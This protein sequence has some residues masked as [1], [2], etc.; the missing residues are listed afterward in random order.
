MS[1][2]HV[3]HLLQPG[4]QAPNFV[5]DAISREGKIA[6][7]D[8][9]GRSPLLIGLFRGLHCPFCRLHVAAMAQLS[10]ALRE[11]GIESLV[12]VSTPV[13]RARLYFR[14]Q[15]IPNLFA[16]SDPERDLHRAFGLPVL[17]FTHNETD[18]P[19]KVGMDVVM[20]MRVD[21]PGELPEPM[22]PPTA[23]DLLNKKDRYEF[24]EADRQV[25]LAGHMQ[26][27]GHF[28][29]DRESVVR[30]S[31]TEVEDEG[32]NVCQALNPEE[33]LSAASQIA[34]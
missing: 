32:R 13:E 25:S 21:R 33:L 15:P 17:E 7:D 31:F 26:L 10:S 18:W 2:C 11:K 19:Y 24:T 30:W 14:Y 1:V 22:A 5:L 9:R 3:E 20:A 23:G 27:V 6:L 29:L 28:L 12:V 4:D 16:A 8:F 34:D